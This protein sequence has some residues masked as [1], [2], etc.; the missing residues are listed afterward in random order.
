MY[1]YSVHVIVWWGY[2]TN[3]LL[4]YIHVCACYREKTIVVGLYVFMGIWAMLIFFGGMGHTHLW[5]I[6]AKTHA[7]CKI[8]RCPQH[9]LYGRLGSRGKWCPIKSRYFHK[10]RKK[11]C[12]GIVRILPDF[13]QNCKPSR[14]NICFIKLATWNYC[15]L[16]IFFL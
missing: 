4:A 7:R 5:L 10:K 16:H 12:P 15:L 3:V 6:F 14:R 11:P 9:F 1:R 13:C 8:Y 2:I